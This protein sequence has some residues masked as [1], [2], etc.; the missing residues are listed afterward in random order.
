MGKNRREAAKVNWMITDNYY[1][2]TSLPSL[3]ELGSTPPISMSQMLERSADNPEGKALLEVIFLSDDL[4]QRQAFLSQEIVE[5]APVV[6]TPEQVR[7]EQPLPD[8]LSPAESQI[9]PRIAEDAVWWAYFRYAFDMATQKRSSF[10]TSWAAQ[11]IGLKNALV[12]ARAKALNLDPTDYLVA[13]EQGQVDEG[14]EAVINE[15]S[16]AATPLAGLRV[17]DKNRWFWLIEH[18][19][20]FSFANDELAAYAAKLMLLQRWSRMASS[21]MSNGSAMTSTQKPT[22]T[23]ERIIQ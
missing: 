21:K 12:I 6:L 5:L 11:E 14:F 18:D 16:A 8:Y 7:D 19:S 1:L 2:I 22:E 13:A 10:L 4:L 20:W 17:L 3:E 9:A 15:W 23:S